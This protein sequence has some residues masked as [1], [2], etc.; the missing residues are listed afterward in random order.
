[1]PRVRAQ[2]SAGLGA[3]AAA[4]AELGSDGFF[5][6][7]LARYLHTLRNL[8]EMVRNMDHIVNRFD[9][10]ATYGYLHAPMAARLGVD[11]NVSGH[12]LVSQPSRVRVTMSSSVGIRQVWLAAYLIKVNAGL[13][14]WGRRC[15]PTHQLAYLATMDLVRCA[16]ESCHAFAAQGL[17][18]LL[19]LAP[20][21]TRSGIAAF[22]RASRSV[23]MTSHEQSLAKPL[24][25]PPSERGTLLRWPA[26]L[27]ALSGEGSC[28]CSLQ[29]EEFSSGSGSASTRLAY[30]TAP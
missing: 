14:A 7:T 8:P 1:M 24:L 12:G 15:L 16:S 19:R 3:A 5:S 30:N 10:A 6:R 20:N 2:L 17:A 25:I 4:G 9:E 13:A 11:L 21:A 26:L 27:R 23:V 28:P 22:A 29:D 18:Q